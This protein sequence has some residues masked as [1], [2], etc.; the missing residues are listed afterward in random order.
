MMDLYYPC[1]FQVGWCEDLDPVL[2]A[3]PQPEC[4][5]VHWAALFHLQSGEPCQDDLDPIVR[6]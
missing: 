1:C 4:Q 6:G 5:P 2:L 3:Y